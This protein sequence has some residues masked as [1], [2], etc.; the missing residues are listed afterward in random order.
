MAHIAAPK[1]AVMGSGV[2]VPEIILCKRIIMTLIMMDLVIHLKPYML[3]PMFTLDI[4]APLMV[5]TA[6]ITTQILRHMFLIPILVQSALAPANAV[7]P[8]TIIV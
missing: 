2:P 1:P 6:M 4:L 7:E 3:A 8:M 5:L